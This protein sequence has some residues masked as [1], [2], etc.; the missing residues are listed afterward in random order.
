M[1]FSAPASFT[2]SFILAAVG[3][4]TLTKT[5]SKEK[6]LL[7]SFPLLFA[8]QQFCEGIVWLTVSKNHL[9][10]I[11]L[12]F[13][14]FY[15]MFAVGVWLL[16]CPLAVY[17]LEKN[18]QLKKLILGIALVGLCQGLYLFG[19]VILNDVN[20]RAFAGHIF[21]DLNFIPFYKA[22]QYL[23]L[24]ITCLPFLIASHRLLK[25]L[26]VLGVISFAVA[27]LF[28][29]ITFVSVWCFFAAVIS[30]FVYLIIADF[31]DNSEPLSG[32]AV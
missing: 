23:Y 29:Q 16:V 7:A 30:A 27:Q 3:T 20:T 15:L 24:L 19:S 5:S 18:P 14:N 6:L 1:C 32:K 11:N 8:T 13:T 21:Y 28:Y 12:I 22:H 17:F 31:K 26:A 2:A 4:L 25:V 9:K 10:S